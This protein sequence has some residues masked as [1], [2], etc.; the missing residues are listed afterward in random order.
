MMLNRITIQN[1]GILEHVSIDFSTEPSRPLTV[2]RADLGKTTLLRAILWVFSG[3]AGLSTA[4]VD[5]PLAPPRLADSGAVP[6]SVA[7][8]F[9]TDAPDG[10]RRYH[11][12]RSCRESWTSNQWTRTDERLAVQQISA[13]GGTAIVEPDAFMKEQTPIG[14]EDILLG[15]WSSSSTDTPPLVTDLIQVG[16]SLS[17][18]ERQRVAVLPVKRFR[19]I[20]TYPSDIAIGGL[21]IK[22]DLSIEACST[23]ERVMDL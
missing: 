17:D 13:T 9:E 19:E 2:I 21:T 15:I 14:I 4:R 5:V 10:R 16:R 22:S 7:V 23:N 3:S 18:G 6:V 20:L 8:E 11:A 12:V 1:C